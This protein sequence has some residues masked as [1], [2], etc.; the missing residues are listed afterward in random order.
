VA[1]PASAQALAFVARR[2]LAES[3][4][5]VFATREPSEE[6]QALPELVVEGLRDQ[7]ARS[8]LAW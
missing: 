4:A 3:V 2:L 6:P 5:V 7:D 1:G 8:L